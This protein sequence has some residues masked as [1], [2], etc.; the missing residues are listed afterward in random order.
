[1]VRIA[2]VPA[3]STVPIEVGA[4]ALGGGVGIGLRG[5]LEAVADLLQALAVEPVA[6]EGDAEQDQHQDAAQPQGLPDVQAGFLPGDDR[7]GP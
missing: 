1:M 5:T 3:G 7:R 4:A 2:G 6:G